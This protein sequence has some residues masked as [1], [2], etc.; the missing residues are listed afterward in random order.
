MP[1]QGFGGL[2]RGPLKSLDDMHD[3]MRD[4][5]FLIGDKLNHAAAEREIVVDCGTI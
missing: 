4:L 2:T 1:R 3:Q 5:A